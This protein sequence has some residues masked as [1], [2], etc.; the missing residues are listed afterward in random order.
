MCTFLLPLIP[1]K[2]SCVVVF[3][4]VFF[5]QQAVCRCGR[6]PAF[7]RDGQEE[8]PPWQGV[9][10][11]RADLRSG[12]TLLSSFT[13]TETAGSCSAGCYSSGA[14]VNLCCALVLDDG[15]IRQQGKQA[16]KKQTTK[17]RKSVFIVSQGNFTLLFLLPWTQQIGLAEQYKKDR[18]SRAKAGSS[19]DGQKQKDVIQKEK[20]MAAPLGWGGPFQLAL[21]S[22]HCHPYH[23]TQ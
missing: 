20:R 23:Q 1:T 13:A 2:I 12:I 4:F 11:H 8:V 5:F 14:G 7:P 15:D 9:I 21:L 19:S 18:K 17:K 16:K 22:Q 10:S 3:V 6:T